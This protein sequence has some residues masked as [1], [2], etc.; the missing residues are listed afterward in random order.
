MWVAKHFINYEHEQW[1]FAERPLN[2]S[3]NTIEKRIII[4]EEFKCP[5]QHTPKSI[6]VFS[7]KE[8]HSI[9]IHW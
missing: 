9:P 5:T 1:K 7:Q 6:N 4:Y 2:R 3:L 8:K